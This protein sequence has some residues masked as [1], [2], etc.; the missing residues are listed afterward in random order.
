MRCNGSWLVG[1]ADG[2]LQ[3]NKAFAVRR[4]RGGHEWPSDLKRC[5]SDVEDM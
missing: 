1:Q 3:I 2:N 4:G 5:K